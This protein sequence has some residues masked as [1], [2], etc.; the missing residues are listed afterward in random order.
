MKKETM[1]ILSD[2]SESQYKNIKTII[3]EQSKVCDGV[4]FELNT[5]F[6][7]GLDISKIKINYK[8]NEKQM[9]INYSN[10]TIINITNKARLEKH[11]KF[12]YINVTSYHMPDNAFIEDESRYNKMLAIHNMVNKILTLFSHQNEYFNDKFLF[13]EQVNNEIELK[14]TSIEIAD[15]FRYGV[16]Q[17]LVL[18]Q[19]DSILDK[20]EHAFK[21]VWI[22][23]FTNRSTYINKI[24]FTKNVTNTYN[25]D[26]IYNDE[27]LSSSARVNETTLIDYINKCII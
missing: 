18:Q 14:N 15:Y 7:L 6:D 23:N 25:V 17:Y 26:L 3:K 24:K 11:N 5:K 2:F 19:I 13:L 9:Q 27:V 20:G 8:P 10:D 4:F 16:K 1:D 22:N 21:E 12:N